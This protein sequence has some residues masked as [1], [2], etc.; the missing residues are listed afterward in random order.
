MRRHCDWNRFREMNLNR[1]LFLSSPDIC[2]RIWGSLRCTL[3]PGLRL[4]HGWFNPVNSRYSE[5]LLSAPSRVPCVHFFALFARF[6]GFLCQS[7]TQGWVHVKKNYTEQNICSK[8]EM[9]WEHCGIFNFRR[10]I[11]YNACMPEYSY[12]DAR[13][14]MPNKV[15]SISEM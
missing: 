9:L 7:V 1:V 3:F 10:W 13:F 6:L 12:P 8:S 2:D 4:L 5:N 15:A 14:S 11:D